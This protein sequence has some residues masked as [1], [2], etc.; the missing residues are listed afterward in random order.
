MVVQNLFC[1]CGMIADCRLVSHCGHP[2]HNQL[3]V[4]IAKDLTIWLL[5][6]GDAPVEVESGELFGYNIGSFTEKGI[7]W[8]SRSL[9]FDIIIGQLCSIC[10]QQKLIAT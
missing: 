1:C 4:C 3:R 2:V 6:E 5:N 10:G 9:S 8:V 7:G